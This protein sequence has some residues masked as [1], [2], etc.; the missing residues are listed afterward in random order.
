MVF[1]FILYLI[2][3]IIYNF[4]FNIKFDFLY[5]KNLK[6]NQLSL[7]IGFLSIPIKK[8]KNSKHNKFRIK[9]KNIKFFNPIDNYFLIESNT[10]ITSSFLQNILIPL[11]FLNFNVI[12]NINT[13]RENDLLHI[14]VL[15]RCNFFMIISYLLQTIKIRWRKNGN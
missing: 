2:I 8:S 4:P 15:V 5:S 1:V 11:K 10:K 3:I 7:N 6:N 13:S 12:E 9:V 14:G